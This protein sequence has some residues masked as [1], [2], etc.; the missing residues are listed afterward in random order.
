MLLVDPMRLTQRWL[1]SNNSMYWSAYFHLDYADDYN[2]V[3][4]T[5]YFSLTVLECLLNKSV[6]S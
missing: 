4:A 1:F 6:S 3:F 5:L 2:L